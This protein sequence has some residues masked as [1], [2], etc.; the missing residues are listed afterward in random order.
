MDCKQVIIDTLIK[1]LSSF[2]DKRKIYEENPDLVWEIL[3]QGSQKA[4]AKARATME[5]V[6]DKIGF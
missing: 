1:E 3:E 5:D 2:R 4:R 6:R